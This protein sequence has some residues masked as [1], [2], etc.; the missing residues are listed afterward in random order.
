MRDI[1]RLVPVGVPPIGL[2]NVPLKLDRQI[3]LTRRV[4]DRK[5]AP[6]QPSPDDLA[7][8]RAFLERHA[9]SKREP[10]T[11]LEIRGLVGLYADS[12]SVASERT[13]IARVLA[14]V[15]GVSRRRLYSV[16]QLRGP[17]FDAL[18]RALAYHVLEV[19]SLANGAVKLP[20]WWPRW[21]G[22]SDAVVRPEPE[23]ARWIAAEG[24][25]FHALSSFR[26]GVVL[27]VGVGEAAVRELVKTGPA[28]WWALSSSI[29]A[30]SVADRLGSA[31]QVAVADRQLRELAGDAGNPAD[32]PPKSDESTAL[33]QW[34]R[35]TFGEPSDS[36]GVWRSFSARGRE[37]MDWLLLR[38]EFGRILEEF[39]KHA[40]QERAIFWAGYLKE[41]RDARYYRTGAGVAVCMMVFRSCMV[42]EFGTTGNA[43][44]VYEKPKVGLRSSAFGRGLEAGDFKDKGALSLGGMSVEFIEKWVH[45]G[46]WERTFYRHLQRRGIVRGGQTPAHWQW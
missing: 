25:P 15:P 7:A 28:P 20:R 23:L 42:I 40:E 35:Q 18:A 9:R 24:I 33:T 26:I 44:Y 30:R 6:S 5:L 37:V 46:G 11:P 39:R 16:W 4:L 38:D 34:C 36:P 21:L 1:R 3:E 17:G 14:A 29:E 12:D 45:T 19:P 43:A 22:S 41:L 2:T 27:S 13:V 31:L 10:P 32:L 8:G